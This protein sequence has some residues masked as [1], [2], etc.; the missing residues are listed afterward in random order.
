LIAISK[1]EKIFW[2]GGMGGVV[3]AGVEEEVLCVCVGGVVIWRDGEAPLVFGAG[4]F[5]EEGGEGG[6]SSEGS[7]RWRN[8]GND[9]KK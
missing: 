7:S 4:G 1:A 2:G 9:T 6:W 3:V 5:E 8:I